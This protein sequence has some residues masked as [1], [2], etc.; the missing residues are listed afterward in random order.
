L[1]VSAVTAMEATSPELGLTMVS[2]ARASFHSS[3]PP[4][5]LHR[6][7]MELVSSS[8]RT[9]AGSRSPE[10]RRALRVTAALAAGMVRDRN[11]SCLWYQSMRLGE[12]GTLVTSPSAVGPPTTSSATAFFP[13]CLGEAGQQIPLS[14]QAGGRW[15]W[16]THGLSGPSRVL[17][18]A[19]VVGLAQ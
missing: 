5:E 12:L 3:I 7:F 13:L 14:A 1:G 15:S 16:A 9:M 10:H 2:L 11:R 17:G 6:G 19:G 4:R 18:R 8:S